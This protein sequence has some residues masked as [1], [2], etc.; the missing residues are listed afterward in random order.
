MRR[1][2]LKLYK[3]LRNIGLDRNHINM[4]TVFDQELKLDKF[5]EACYLYYLENNFNILIPDQDLVQLKTIDKTIN[6]LYDRTNHVGG[7]N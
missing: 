3:I 2:K 1:I 6:Y 5:D 4:F 7:L